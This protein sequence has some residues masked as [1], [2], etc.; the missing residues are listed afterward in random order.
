MTTK[1]DNL[2]SGKFQSCCLNYNHYIKEFF[3]DL[4]W[5]EKSLSLSLQFSS[6]SEEQVDELTQAIWLPQNIKS[7]IIDYDDAVSQDI[8]N[9]P[10]YSYR[11]LIFQKLVNRKWQADRVI[12]FIDPKSEIAQWVGKEYR[13]QKEIERPK[14]L[15][16]KVISILQNEWY[17]NFWIGKHTR[18]WKELD[19]K[20]LSKWYGVLVEGNRYWYENRFNVV[21]EYLKKELSLSNV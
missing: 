7:F 12:E 11:T 13:V 5:I 1:I 3:G 17:I 21:R 10:K 9:D 19:W 16:K 20:N 18:I 14:F 8:F 6:L 2:M 4:Y 15:P